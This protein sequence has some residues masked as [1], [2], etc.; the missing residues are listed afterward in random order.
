MMTPGDDQ[1][2]PKIAMKCSV[3]DA[4]CPWVR[5]Y[6]AKFTQKKR[7]NMKTPKRIPCGYKNKYENEL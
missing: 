5:W 7:I 1:L 4:R 6:L 2:G 3:K